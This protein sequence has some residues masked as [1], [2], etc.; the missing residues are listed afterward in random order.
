MINRK[1]WFRNL[2]CGLLITIGL[3][4]FGSVVNA[5][6]TDSVGDGYKLK[7]ESINYV[8][9]TNKETNKG[10]ILIYHTHTHEDYKDSDVV[11]LGE[12]LAIKLE[13]KGY[14]VDHVVEDME[15]NGYNE[16]YNTSRAY[17]KGVDL[18]RYSLVIDM[19][20]DSVPYPNTVNVKGVECARGMLVYSKNSSGYEASQI[21]GN[22]IE[23]Y[24]DRFNQSL[25]RDGWYY[26]N[27]INHF[28][29]DLS[30]NMILFEAGNNNNTKVEVQRLN[31]YFASSIEQFLSE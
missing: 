17:L 2:V 20:R 5:M 28:N 25:M 24:M 18:S 13:K 30:N 15:R 7:E 1:R 8:V 21:K 6:T 14:I 19:H 4:L 31:T 29:T 11:D 26:N 16:S 10:R 3:G 23:K 9:G 12:D 27:G 22:G